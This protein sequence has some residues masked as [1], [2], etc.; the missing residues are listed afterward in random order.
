MKKFLEEIK[1]VSFESCFPDEVSCLKFLSELKWQKAYHCRKCGHTNYCKGKTPYS[2]RC[3]R[4][5]HEESAASHTIFHNCRIPLAKAFHIAYMVCNNPEVSTYKLSDC[6][7]IRQMTCWKFKKK[8]SSC[9][10]KGIDLTEF[11][12]PQPL[13]PAGPTS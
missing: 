11:I 4:C 1:S 9:L 12:Q 10:D 3:T 7:E 13:K 6:L 8:I 2:R 5:K